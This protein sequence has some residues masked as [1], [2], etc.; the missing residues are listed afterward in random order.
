M[1]VGVSTG[2]TPPWQDGG[3]TVL[4]IL[5]AACLPRHLQNV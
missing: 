4:L 2:K 1:N 3:T 5:Q